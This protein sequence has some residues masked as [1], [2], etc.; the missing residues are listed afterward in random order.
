MTSNELKKIG[1]KIDSSES[2]EERKRILQT[3]IDNLTNDIER[4]DSKKISFLDMFNR[5]LQAWTGL[6]VGEDFVISF[7]INQKGRRK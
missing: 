7:F 6:P 4:L 5:Y 2:L 3:S 1:R